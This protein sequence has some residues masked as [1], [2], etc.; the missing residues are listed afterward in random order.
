M[1]FLELY[2]EDHDIYATYSGRN[3]HRVRPF[4]MRE[5]VFH[6]LCGADW[7]VTVDILLKVSSRVRSDESLFG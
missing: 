4:H 6:Q 5:N 7:S 3:T 1:A 2:I